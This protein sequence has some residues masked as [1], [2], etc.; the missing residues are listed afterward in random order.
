MKQ[1]TIG[2]QSVEIRSPRPDDIPAIRKLVAAGGPWLTTHHEY[3]FWV[4]VKCSEQISLVAEL[5]GQVVGW[6]SVFR[7]SGDG[8]L[9]HQ[10]AVAPELRHKGIAVSIVTHLLNKL[11]R[12]IAMFHLEFTIDRRNKAAQKFFD[13]VARLSGMQIIAKDE[14]VPVTEDGGEEQLYELVGDERNQRA[15]AFAQDAA[16]DTHGED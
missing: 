5:D 2:V 15:F 6:C 16:K 9:L 4:T 12:E 8:F 13:S 3:V 7:K 10:L 1:L 14:K 11:R